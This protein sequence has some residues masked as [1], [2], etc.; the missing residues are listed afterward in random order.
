MSAA[1]SGK[2]ELKSLVGR[3]LQGVA[4]RA[5]Y[6][7]TLLAVKRGEETLPNPRPDFVFQ[8]DDLLIVFGSPHHVA[9]AGALARGTDP[10]EP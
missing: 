3:T 8:P 9:D 1:G 5:E 4:L 2:V 10:W 6:E 7:V